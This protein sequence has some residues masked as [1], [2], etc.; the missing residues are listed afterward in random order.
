[1][2]MPSTPSRPS[3]LPESGHSVVALPATSPLSVQFF[4]VAYL[5]APAIVSPKLASLIA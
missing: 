2:G 4:I 3:L 5:S 1:M